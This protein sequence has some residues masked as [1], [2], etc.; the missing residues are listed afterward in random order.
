VIFVVAVFFYVLFYS[1][2]AAQPNSLAFD[3]F[4]Y[5]LAALGVAFVS[6]GMVDL[7][8]HG[9]LAFHWSTAGKACASA[10]AGVGLTLIS[11]PF[12]PYGIFEVSYT[13][14]PIPFSSTTTLIG[15]TF[16]TGNPLAFAIDCGFWIAI[17]YPVIWFVGSVATGR[18][19]LVRRLEGVTL[20]ASLTYGVYPGWAALVSVSW[21]SSSLGQV[22]PVS[23]VGFFFLPSL[24]VGALIAAKG[25]R[26]L[27][28]TIVLG[29][30]MF[31]SLLGLAYLGASLHVVL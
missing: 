11:A 13:G 8:V 19:N 25:N 29:S 16:T 15:E 28:L 3:L 24:I 4:S 2:N 18:L 7:V 14:F 20:A 10:V 6:G 27:G 12:P 23:I 9:G 22:G 17:A 31:D 5:S 21:F 26:R 30:L 1:V